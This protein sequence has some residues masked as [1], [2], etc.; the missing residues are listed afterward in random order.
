MILYF[1]NKVSSHGKTPTSVETLGKRLEEIDEVIRF[2]DK[3]YPALRMLDML[4]GAIRFGHK[5]EYVLIDT[6]SSKAFY[7][8]LLIGAILKLIQV[9]YVPILHGGNL[10]RRLSISPILCKFLFTNAYI[11]IAPSGYIKSSL[12]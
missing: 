1:G 4:L 6:Y 2:S 12:S 8:A 7:Y 3:K 10:P 5:A 11:N 9:K